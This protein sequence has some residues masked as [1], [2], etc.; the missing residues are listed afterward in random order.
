LKIGKETVRYAAKLASIRLEDREEERYAAELLKILDYFRLL[1]EL[2]TEG[3]ES[4]ASPIP[5]NGFLREDEIQPSL[6]RPLILDNAPQV[7]EGC[8]RV[9][10]VL[11]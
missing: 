3:I 10:R 6:H 7:E 8:Y 4:A 9:P 2:D 1:D 11:E 5:S